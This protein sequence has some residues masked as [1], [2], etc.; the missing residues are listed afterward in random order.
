[1]PNEDDSYV[2]P[3]LA[4][5]SPRMRFH[6]N[7]TRNNQPLIPTELPD[8]A[9]PPSP[10]YIAQWNQS[11]YITA[12]LVTR[13]DPATRDPILGIA[14]YAFEGPDRHT[15]VR[16]Y[17]APRSWVY[18]LYQ[19]GGSLQIG[20]GTNLFL[21]TDHVAP[22]AT[23]DRRITADFDA[24]L[25]RAAIWAPEA[26][27][28]SGAVLSMLFAGF[29]FL[30]TDPANG[31]QDFIFMQLPIASSR[32]ISR[33]ATF[34]S[35][36]GRAALYLPNLDHGEPL[37]PYES[38]SGP[39][40]R[41]HYELNDYLQDLLT[42]DICHDEWS[43]PQREVR[44]WRLNTFYIGLETEAR[45]LRPESRTTEP[46]GSVETAVQI[47]NVSVRRQSP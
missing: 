36:H 12:A 16:A 3:P 9:E 29:G 28:A 20:G 7:E 44:H 35:E 13:N 33:K 14:T 18:E 19:A 15:H 10:Y 43:A 41:F 42:K 24:K 31:S 23:M 39:L 17:P 22:D 6:Q 47:A 40:H 45:D 11:S 46:Q 30:Y 26:A 38:D 5:A 2:I 34:M 4:A 1:M 27:Q 21:T 37:L 8:I 32:L 25:S